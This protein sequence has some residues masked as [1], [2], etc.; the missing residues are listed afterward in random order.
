MCSGHCGQTTWVWLHRSR[1]AALAAPSRETTSNR[2]DPGTLQALPHKQPVNCGLHLAFFFFFSGV[3]CMVYNQLTV[4]SIWP[5]FIFFS[6]VH[7]MVYRHLGPKM[8][9]SCTSKLV[10][11]RCF[12][13][14]DE[15]RRGSLQHNFIAKCQYT[16]C[17]RNVL[18]CQVHSSH[19]HSNHKTLNYNNSK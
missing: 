17:T 15:W 10:H 2:C 8:L 4:G 5:F 14:T 13:C 1:L 3:H 11:M 6:G 7:C 12:E 16:D 19:I 9:Y 18:W